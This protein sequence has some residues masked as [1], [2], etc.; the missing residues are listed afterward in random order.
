[1]VDFANSMGDNEQ[2]S[3]VR[4]RVATNMSYVVDVAQTMGRDVKQRVATRQR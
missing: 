4:Q 1:M 2:G 3:D